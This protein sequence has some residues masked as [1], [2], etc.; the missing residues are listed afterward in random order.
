M[1]L[2]LV[3][4]TDN[5]VFI[6]IQNEYVKPV[7]DKKEKTENVTP[8]QEPMETEE[9]KT[10]VKIEA[11]QEENSDATSTTLSSQT[12]QTFKKSKDVF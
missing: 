6:L 10:E 8:K 5:A 9:K 4:T 12:S 1:E 11:K 2:C 7:A 3:L